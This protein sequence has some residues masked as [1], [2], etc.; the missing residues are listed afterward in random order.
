MLWQHKKEISG[1]DG[2]EAQP[3]FYFAAA[4]ETV[5]MAS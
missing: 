2:R 4:A 3:P 1:F 5:E